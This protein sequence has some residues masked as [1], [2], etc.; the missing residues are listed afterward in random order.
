MFHVIQCG[1]GDHEEVFTCST[2]Y[3]AV[4]IQPSCKRKSY[5]WAKANWNQINKMAKSFCDDFVVYYTVDTNV[6]VLWSIFKK[7][8]MFCLTCIPS[9]VIGKSHD[10]P[11]LSPFIKQLARRKQ[12][13]YNQAHLTHSTEDWSVYYSI[14]K[15]CQC[16]CRKA[17]N[18]YISK[19]VDS[20]GNVSK[21]LWTFIKDKRN[22]QFRKASLK[23]NGTMY[24]TCKDKAS[25]LNEYFTSIFTNENTSYIPSLDGYSFPDIS[26]IDGTIAG[27]TAL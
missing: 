7:F 18:Y 5:S 9:K 25:V 20:N 11:W 15:E 26:P 6:D 27:V 10:H 1:I 2:V 24:N 22:D 13:A 12:R 4:D 17:Y 14:K 21:R 23:V 16:E 19:L 8:C 3:L